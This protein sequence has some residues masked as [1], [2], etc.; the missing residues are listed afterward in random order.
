M[1]IPSLFGRSDF[2]DDLLDNF[3]SAP[4]APEKKETVSM[5]QTDIRE[6][7]TSYELEMEL[8]GYQKSD[9]QIELKDGYL[10][11]SAVHE[12][13]AED[14]GTPGRYIRKERYTGSCRRSFYIGKH[15]KQDDVR[16]AFENGILKLAFPKEN[17]KP[18][19]EE[20]KFIFI[21]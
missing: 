17:A 1:I 15:V 20:K 16:A 9:I 12:V 11:I 18:Q 14:K 19:E 5:M 3:F 8:P 21:E 13:N 10:T 2:T 6:Y 7:E 4:A